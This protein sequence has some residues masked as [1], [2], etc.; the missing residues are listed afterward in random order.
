M[1][2]ASHGPP[3]RLPPRI[4]PLTVG[5]LGVAAAA[6]SFFV[7]RSALSELIPTKN[8]TSVR[9]R[10]RITRSTLGGAKLQRRSLALMPSETPFV[11]FVLAIGGLLTVVGIAVSQIR[12]ARVRRL[13]DE[14][15][16]ARRR[17]E[18]DDKR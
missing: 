16:D 9:G 3:V 11:A 14:A 15:Y 10:R 18:H 6:A 5:V 4:G 1:G 12:A 8:A 2:D 17:A 13:H 7:G